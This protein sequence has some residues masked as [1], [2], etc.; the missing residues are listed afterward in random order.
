MKFLAGQGWIA[1]YQLILIKRGYM[2]NIIY[3]ILMIH[4]VRYM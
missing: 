1:L 4:S 3:D 2:Y